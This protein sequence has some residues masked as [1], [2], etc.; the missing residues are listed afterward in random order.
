M[1][2]S[3]KEDYDH[4]GN[5][6]K[7][8]HVA[9]PDAF[10]RCLQ[11]GLTVLAHAYA[12]L[13]SEARLLYFDFDHKKGDGEPPFTQDEATALA[14]TVLAFVCEH[15]KAAFGVDPELAVQH[16]CVP[17]KFSIH[18]VVQNLALVD[19]HHA[20]TYAKLLH[21]DMAARIPDDPA[22]TS[23]KFVDVS[24]YSKN[25]PWRLGGCSK[26]GKSNPLVPLRWTEKSTITF[27]KPA[28]FA[29]LM[30]TL[31][32][33]V[34]GLP[35]VGLEGLPLYESP[36]KPRVQPAPV[37]RPRQASTPHAKDESCKGTE[38]SDELRQL[39]M[40]LPAT[41]I[42]RYHP[43][44]HAMLVIFAE[45]RGS[46]EGYQLFVEMSRNAPNFDEDECRAKWAK[47]SYDAVAHV[48]LATLY[49]YLKP[50][51]APGAFECVSC[52]QAFSS[53]YK[54]HDHCK[55]YLYHK[56][57]NFQKA[58]SPQDWTLLPDHDETLVPPAPSGSICG[59]C[60]KRTKR[61]L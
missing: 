46:A 3:D 9:T 16:A 26:R 8:Y 30:P 40:S 7:S 12:I 47:I 36:V 39:I 44:M 35:H 24:V 4:G 51:P 17:A 52:G 34:R 23:P 50:A 11:R 28:P 27:T 22:I 19:H 57:T 60:V 10:F 45:T 61:F 53:H 14:H 20:K 29:V 37:P 13:D 54:L 49:S 31:D 18:V 25:Q 43:W 58:K 55:Q 41:R 48:T 2:A 33:F 1:W 6:R 15:I 38:P 42:A 59:H 5:A 56:A 21:R 32:E